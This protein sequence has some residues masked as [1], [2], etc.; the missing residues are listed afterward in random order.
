ML[1]SS[2]KGILNCQ[3]LSRHLPPLRDPRDSPVKTKYISPPM[4][5]SPK[6]SK[7]VD[8]NQPHALYHPQYTSSP[9]S[10]SSPHK[11]SP[12]HSKSSK[13]RPPESRRSLNTPP[14]NTDIESTGTPLHLSG[15]ARP[16]REASNEDLSPN[17]Q[18]SPEAHQL[19]SGAPGIARRAKA[20][21]P[22][23]CV[24]CKRKHLACETKRPCN[25][26]LQ[27]GKEVSVFQNAAI[28]WLISIRRRAWMCNTRKEVDLGFAKRKLFEKS[29]L[30]A[31]TLMLKPKLMPVTPA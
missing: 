1:V 19:T 18:D 5:A 29:A 9:A 25:R 11:E 24:N 15:D 30:E 8:S 28:H 17:P 3:S 16:L 7:F 14:R 13:P 27:T 21:V 4:S 10:H 22:S 23:A 2:P 20:H 26:C 31:S 12:R 6:R